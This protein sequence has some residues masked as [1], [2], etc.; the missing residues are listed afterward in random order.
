MKVRE[1][2]ARTTREARPDVE[3]LLERARLDEAAQREKGTTDRRIR[4]TMSPATGTPVLRMNRRAA[5]RRFSTFNLILILFGIAGAVILYI[6]NIISVNHIA[7]EVD[8]LKTE[9]EELLN[10]QEI[11]NAEV[12]R[13]SGRDRI[14]RIAA[15]QLGLTF[16]QGQPVWIVVD[17]EDGK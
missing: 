10:A 13:K 12:D 15:E 4:S 2:S 11:L 16:P 6:S 8:H 14:V 5:R 9:R 17:E 7:V 3:E 1:Q